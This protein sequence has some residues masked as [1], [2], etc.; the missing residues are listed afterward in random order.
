MKTPLCLAYEVYS[1]KLGQYSDLRADGFAAVYGR[2]VLYGGQLGRLGRLVLFR[3][4]CGVRDYG[5]FRRLRGAT[6]RPD[7]PAGYVS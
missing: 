2:V 1:E 4:V 7:H 3:T 6:I 5:L